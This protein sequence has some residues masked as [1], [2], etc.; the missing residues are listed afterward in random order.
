M[1]DLQKKNW[2][3]FSYRDWYAYF[4]RNDARRLKIDFSNEKVL[5]DAE[6]ALILPSVRAFQKGEHSEGFQFL[7]LAKKFAADRNRP[8]YTDA[9]SLFIK[10]EN[11]HSAYLAQFM[12]HYEM[13]M[14]RENVLDK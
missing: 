5:T 7:E 4:K 12:T 13:Q 8:L 6:R 3:R 9:I 2:V 11:F 10:E 1:Y 14:E